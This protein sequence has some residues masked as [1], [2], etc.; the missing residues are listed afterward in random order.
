MSSSQFPGANGPG[1]VYLAGLNIQPTAHLF[2]LLRSESPLAAGN[3]LHLTLES[4]YRFP[5]PVPPGIYV[6]HWAILDVTVCSKG[7]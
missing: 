4:V 6:P 1:S 2:Y 5:N 7:L 3:V